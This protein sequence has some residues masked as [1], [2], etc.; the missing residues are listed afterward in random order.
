MRYFLLLFV[1]QVFVQVQAQQDSLRLKLHSDSLL[2][3]V[4]VT[5]FQSA[6]NWKNVAAAVAVLSNQDLN[7][8]NTQSFLPA[9]NAVAGVRMEERSPSSYRVAIRGSS[10]RSPF[11]FRNIKV[12]WDAIPLSDG[13]GNTY[14]NLVNVS[15]VGSMEILKG[16][17]AS[18]YGAG[19]GGVMLLKSAIPDLPDQM[20][21]EVSGGTYNSLNEFVQW[22]HRQQDFSSSIQQV[23][24]QGDGYRQQSA[25]RKDILQWQGGWHTTQQEL[26][27]IAFYTDLYY[28]TP[29][30]LTL[31]QMMQNPQTAR[32]AS[33]TI[34]G[35]VQAKAAIYNKT[36]FA[37]MHHTVQWSPSWYT[38]SAVMLNHTTFDNPFLTD[39]EQRDET[40][41]GVKAQMVYH[42]HFGDYALQWNTG[43]EW[44]YNHSEINDYG[45]RNGVKDT[46]QFK[47]N[48]YANQ[49]FAFTQL[50]VTG[51]RF[52]LDAGISLNNQL[53]RYKRLTDPS[54]LEYAQT[55]SKDILTPRFSLLY[56]L[57]SQVSWYALV[58]KGFSPPSLA[59]LHPA[60]GLFHP[61]LQPE[62]GWNK[63]T[64][65]K[66]YLLHEKLWF[67]LGLYDFELQQ[68]IVS[69]NNAAGQAYFV[70]AG[71]ISEKGIEL[72]VRQ[73]IVDNK[74]G[75]IRTFNWQTSFSYQPYVFNNYIQG[76]HNYSGN[77]V[78]GVPKY[79]W[80]SSVELSLANHFYTNISMNINS[81]IPVNDANDEYAKAYHL[82]QVKCGKMIVK[83]KLTIHV[84][85]GGDNLLNE[86][87]SLGNDINA[88]GRRY[89]NTAAPRNYYGG[90]RITL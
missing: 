21:A 17:A 32:P 34:P 25:S 75:F 80:V 66:G 26:S 30:G 29:G 87:Y 56:R 81:E 60:D 18:M 4:V 13:G 90:V 11:G 6:Q 76:G 48:V 83:G 52:I 88:A 61:D 36:A 37:G 35:A 62:Y 77:R 12:Y 67:D 63:E 1:F 50:Q 33:G 89:Y 82:L 19:T 72:F 3:E 10:L 38:E 84:F 64:G 9:V 74:K 51:Q 71:S 41:T 20:K 2:P 79:V 7:K 78:T 58:A 65:I 27:F 86:V 43:A 53:Y 73:L 55:N 8:Q 70:N 31:A 85:V 22:N 16:P 54:W 40:N 68:S 39:Y 42:H 23:H 46:V 59:E 57:N 45:N 44:L 5:A 14:I 49:W 15:E 47:D 24:Q 69:R 28:Q